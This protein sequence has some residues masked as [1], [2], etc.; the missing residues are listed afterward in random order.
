LGANNQKLR[1]WCGNGKPDARR[2]RKLLGEQG[3]G[4]EA[5]DENDE[6]KESAEAA[7]GI[8]RGRVVDRGHAKEAKAEKNGSPEKPAG[9]TAE[10]AEKKKRSGK[11]KRKETVNARAD[12]AK[13]VT[14]IELAGGKEIEGSGEKADPRSASDGMKE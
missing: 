12:R 13:D 5:E 4:H 9:P 3:S 6:G 10:E 14:A 1:G 11:K 7:S 8:E 2:T